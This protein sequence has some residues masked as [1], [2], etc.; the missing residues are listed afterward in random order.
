MLYSTISAGRRNLLDLILADFGGGEVRLLFAEVV[1]TY[2]G[3]LCALE[4][5]SVISDRIAGQG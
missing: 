4:L 1:E 5:T 3:R 2:I